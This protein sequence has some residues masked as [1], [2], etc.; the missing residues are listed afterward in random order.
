MSPEGAV[1]TNVTR[2]THFLTLTTTFSHQLNGDLAAVLGY[3]EIMAD[4]AEVDDPVKAYAA[5]ILA[6]GRNVRSIVE[7]FQMLHRMAS[8]EVLPFDV[9]QPIE[10]IRNLL[11]CR[12][13]AGIE[14]E[15]TMPASPI[16]VNGNPKDLEPVLRELCDVY[17]SMIGFSGAIQV[18]IDT[19]D[20][21]A[22]QRLSRGLLPEGAYVRISIQ[23]SPTDDDTDDARSEETVNF[24]S[25]YRDCLQGQLVGA[26]SAVS[27]MG[28]ILHL[29]SSSDKYSTSEIYLPRLLPHA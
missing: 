17:I 26:R 25:A 14:F 21:S 2:L 1:V 5:E 3:A 28:G 10:R 13:D 23:C 18:T 4:A 11:M 8:A 12:L 19:L 15:T 24:N 20:T 7:R 9:R 27:L 16:M 6:A 22:E 29:R